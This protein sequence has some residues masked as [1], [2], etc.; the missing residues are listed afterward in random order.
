MQPYLWKEKPGHQTILNPP[1]ST[2]NLSCLQDGCIACRM[3]WC[4]DGAELV[5]VANQ[6][7]VELEANATKESPC[8]TLPGWPKTRDM[9]S[10]RPRIE[11]NSLGKKIKKMIPNDILLD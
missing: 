3:Y 7:L 5:E 4:N 6:C 11:A 2:Y 1:P 8:P 10:Q 9:I